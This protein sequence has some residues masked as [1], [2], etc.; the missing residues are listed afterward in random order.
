MGRAY[1]RLIRWLNM[2]VLD[3]RLARKEEGELLA[4][5][6]ARY[7]EC[8]RPTGRFLPRLLGRRPRIVARTQTA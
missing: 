2:A 8:R 5:C 1:R 6:G 4:Q 7:A 3:Y